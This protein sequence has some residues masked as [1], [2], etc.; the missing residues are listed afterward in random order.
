MPLYLGSWP[1]AFNF[2]KNI[3]LYIV[4]GNINYGRGV[5]CV[6]EIKLPGKVLRK[7]ISPTWTKTNRSWEIKTSVIYWSS[8]LNTAGSGPQTL[9][10]PSSVPVS[11]RLNEHF[12]FWC[13]GS[14]TLSPLHTDLQALNFQNFEHALVCQLLDSALHFK[15]LYCKVNNT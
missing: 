2:D 8:I 13:L 4:F 9:P 3:Y 7:I 10:S 15:V 12:H 14:F 1:P 11:S 5:R 6:R